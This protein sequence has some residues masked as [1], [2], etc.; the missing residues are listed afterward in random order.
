MSKAVDAGLSG[1][2]CGSAA[3]AA[4]ATLC[5]WCEESTKREAKRGR[6]SVKELRA[7]V[8]DSI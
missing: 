4:A 3:V 1:E 2:C 8:G 5:Q 6:V 7:D